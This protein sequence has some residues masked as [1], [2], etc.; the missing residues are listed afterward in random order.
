MRRQT[1]II[2]GA[3]DGI[4]AEAARA[5]GRQGHEVVVVGRNQER[6]A[7]VAREINADYFLVD[8][9]DLGEVRNLAALLLEKYPR[10]DVLANNAGGIFTPARQETTDGFEM[11]FQVN[12]LAPFLLSHLL[13]DRLVASRATVINTSS[14]ANRLY[15]N[16]DLSDLNAERYYDPKRA[17]GNAKLE[18]IMFTRELQRRFG[19]QGLVSASFHPG[20]VSTGFSRAP[21]ASMESIYGNWFISKFL[22]SPRKGA[23][24]LIWLAS[25][26][27]GKTWPSGE[28]FTRRK[29]AVTNPQANDASLCAELWNRSQKLLQIG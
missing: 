11:T 21:G 14:V 29:V 22:A 4:G 20:I 9:S 23:D 18:Q 8:F 10:I 16:V 1:I 6:T 19:P 2:T 26:D 15:G 12:Y 17:Y 25:Q 7:A 13:L 3:S 24:T 5:L 28:F 27:H